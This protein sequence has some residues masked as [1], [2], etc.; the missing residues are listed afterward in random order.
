MSCPF[1]NKFPY[2][3]LK[4]YSTTVLNNYTNKCPVMSRRLSSFVSDDVQATSAKSTQQHNAPDS[5]FKQSNN[6]A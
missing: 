2:N 5:E 1:L 6:F 3:F 4:R